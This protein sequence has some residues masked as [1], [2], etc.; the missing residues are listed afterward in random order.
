MPRR[1]SKAG[2][3]RFKEE[4][5]MLKMLQHPNILKFHD[6]FESGD[7]K[8]RTVVLVTEL[9]TSGT[10]KTYL[11]RFKGE[12]VR[13]KVL[14]SWCLQI[15]K[16]LNFLHSHTPPIIHRDL[17]CDNIFIT[18]T[19]GLVKIGDLGMAIL[20]HKSH[21]ESVI[22][23]PEFMA[24]EMYEERYDESVDVYAFG[25]CVVEMA[26]LEYPYMECQNAAQIYRKVTSGVMPLCLSKVENPLL[27]KIISVCL[28][29]DK[30]GRSSIKQLLN[31]EFFKE[32][33]ALSV[34]HLKAEKSSETPSV[35]DM[36]M[37][38]VD[39]REKEESTLVEFKFNLAS[40]SPEEVAK[41]MIHNGV[42]RED[43]FKM[44][45]KSIRLKIREVK[46][47]REL[48]ED[49]SGE[50][51]A[52][53]PATP[54]PESSSQ[55]PPVFTASSTGSATSTPN[56]GAA[57]TDSVPAAG[58]IQ[59]QCAVVVGN[60]FDGARTN[61]EVKGHLPDKED[62]VPVLEHAPVTAAPVLPATPST[63]APSSVTVPAASAAALPTSSV[64]KTQAYPTSAAVT[65][66]PS[67]TVQVAPGVPTSASNHVS[68]ASSTSSTTLTDGNGVQA[69]AFKPT[70]GSTA[71]SSTVKQPLNSS[72][73]SN[74]ASSSSGT[75]KPRQKGTKA[76]VAKDV[77]PPRLAW[78]RV[79]DGIVYCSL[80]NRG[81]TV[82]FHFS[83]DDDVPEDVAHSM[84]TSQFIAPGSE[85]KLSSMLQDLVTEAIAVLSGQPEGTT[86]VHR[87]PDLPGT[88]ESSVGD[89]D[90]PAQV[91]TMAS[92]NA[93][94]SVAAGASAG[95]MTT[96]AG[97]LAPI[98]T[99]SLLNQQLSSAVTGMGPVH[100]QSFLH[101]RAMHSTA[102]DLNSFANVNDR[103]MAAA[104]PFA[105]AGMP[106]LATETS[107]FQL[108]H[109]S[110][111]TFSMEMLNVLIHDP[112]FVLMSNRHRSE[113]K[114]LKDRHRCEVERYLQYLNRRYDDDT[115]TSRPRSATAPP[116]ASLPAQQ[117]ALSAQ[118]APE[119]RAYMMSNGY[120]ANG[121]IDSTSMHLAGNSNHTNA[122]SNGG[123]TSAVVLHAA[124][125]GHP[126]TSSD[127]KMTEQ[128]YAAA[129][130][131][132]TTTVTAT[133]VPSQA[134]LPAQQPGQQQQ[135]SQSSQ[136][137][138]SVTSPDQVSTL[139]PAQQ[140][141]QQAQLLTQA[142]VQPYMAHATAAQQTAILHAHALGYAG[143]IP[144]QLHHIALQ[145]QQ[146]PLAP[147]AQQHPLA[148]AAQQQQP[149]HMAPGVQPVQMMPLQGMA[150]QPQP[151]QQQQP[152]QTPQSQQQP[153]QQA[154]AG[155]QVAVAPGQNPQATQGQNPQAAPGQGPNSVAIA[156]QQQQQQSASAGPQQQQQ[157]SASA[158]QQQQ[159][160]QENSVQILQQQPQASSPAQFQQAP[161]TTSTAG[162]GCATVAGTAHVAAT[163]TTT[164]VASSQQLP[165]S[166][167]Q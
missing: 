153:Q 86:C 71:P 95:M 156:Q 149:F 109:D 151:Q 99:A 61:S 7:K 3:T 24:P 118:Q 27:R 32:E 40:D 42:L 28:K 145:Q 43:H 8:T 121:M 53:I 112:Q 5:Q 62:T 116:G 157:Q 76:K 48:D 73:T 119:S 81:H 129:V 100:A 64:V 131:A 17:K 14:R 19:T 92:V 37:E 58:E 77:R 16:G 140:Q 31:H 88:G 154:A 26:T 134:Q 144:Q 44:V 108:N 146:H 127:S 38:V 160:Q 130:A 18:G 6:F 103:L 67:A 89:A 142:H 20:R 57:P 59:F 47:A 12:G 9:M 85:T 110:T 150:Y 155:T 128:T 79:E 138:N 66:E 35:L 93:N 10:L 50:A 54:T 164:T 102:G 159:Q 148:P 83:L 1:Y 46:E 97:Q 113:V 120:A 68:V 2:I 41:D 23:T 56:G 117:A 11:K 136:P 70:S 84:V 123:P 94:G 137:Q 143:G 162:G 139:T 60:H 49:R 65:T 158:S 132:S 152:P 21:A 25:M 87:P 135:Q 55:A 72:A 125:N 122:S 163:A 101:N 33:N 4:A 126:R 75:G 133:G 45:S 111:F 106:P 69:A 51:S 98:V 78:E 90:S 104:H 115:I 124:T 80:V 36:R 167:A 114:E 29:S 22:G 107:L 39:P 30:A 96:A 165:V 74:N 147:A 105:N 15:L 166:A 82:E 13:P 63:V 91:L 161:A 141:L 52:G 34:I